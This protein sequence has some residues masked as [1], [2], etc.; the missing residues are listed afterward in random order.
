MRP[1]IPPA[2]A[3]VLAEV[4]EARSFSVA[5]A[6]LRTVSAA[7]WKPGG[8]RTST[9]GARLGPRPTAVKA[10]QGCEGHAGVLGRDAERRAGMGAPP[11]ATHVPAGRSRP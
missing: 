10:M 6:P 2:D 11:L 3:R 8:L 9:H 1:Q 7:G 4:F 5:A